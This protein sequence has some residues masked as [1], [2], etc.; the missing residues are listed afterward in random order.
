MNRQQKEESVAQFKEM[1]D[2]AQA[3]FLVKYKGLTVLQMQTLRAG[4]REGNG[5][6]KITKARLMKIAAQD[7]PDGA[8]F[9]E[10]FKNQVGLVFAFG[11]VPPIAKHLI[12]FAKKNE[13]LEVISG[14]FEAKVMAPDQIRF[15]ASLPSKQ[16]LYGQLAGTLQ[17]PIGAL[18]RQLN[19]MVANLAYALKAVAEQKE[20][21]GQ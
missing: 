7:L 14:L 9:Q 10:N 2:K 16:E 3:A 4:L 5:K 17:A 11:E 21:E 20:K 8:A 15:L 12:K 6:L 13:A 18:A 1:F 19:S